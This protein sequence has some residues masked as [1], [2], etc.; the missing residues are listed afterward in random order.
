MTGTLATFISGAFAGL[1]VGGFG[2]CIAMA[3]FNYARSDD[4]G[5]GTEARFPG[6]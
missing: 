4:E 3:L 2:G 1:L 5:T 6:K